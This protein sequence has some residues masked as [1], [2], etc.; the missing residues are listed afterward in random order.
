MRI[1]DSDYIKLVEKHLHKLTVLT[2]KECAEEVKTIQDGAISSFEPHQNA[3]KG[4]APTGSMELPS[5]Q[6]PKRRGR[7]PGT[8]NKVK[9]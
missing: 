6:Q 4:Q 8:K 7:P 1:G 3:W 9:S 5:S 2:E